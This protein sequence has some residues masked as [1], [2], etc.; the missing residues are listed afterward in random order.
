MKYYNFDNGSNNNN[1]NNNN[2][3]NFKNNNNNMNGTITTTLKKLI[4]L[5][6]VL[7]KIIIM[8][9]KNNLY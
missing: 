7:S 4:H 8:H 9:S 6:E 5:N 3:T 2:N 1:N